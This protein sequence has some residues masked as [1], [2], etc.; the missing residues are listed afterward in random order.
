MQDAVADVLAQRSRLG[1]GGARRGL[2]ASLALHALMLTA[3]FFGARQ[4]IPRPT[5]NVLNIRFAPVAASQPAP[6][7]STPAP[8]KA[9]PAPPPPPPVVVEQTPPAK[10]EAFAPK[11]ESLFGKS[12]RKVEPPA[13]TTPA[14]A[15]KAP[16]PAAAVTPP[17]VSGTGDA[18]GFA[19]PGIGTAGVTGLE[20]GDFPYTI[21]VN[22]MVSK[23]G[24]NWLRPQ[25]GGEPLAEVYFVINRDGTI[26]DA[27]ISTASGNSTF[28]R[29]ALRAVLASSP[30]PP[31][32]FGYSGTWLGVRLTFH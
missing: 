29:A 16:P 27:K 5:P 15:T 13:V 3:I 14:P 25:A 2:A 18:S 21:Y 7:V 17:P 20:G 24:S 28:D 4:T 11:Q 12:D 10:K 19:T 31:L 26:R 9:A 22:Q 32:P 8:V 6:V 30:L 1:R 23:I